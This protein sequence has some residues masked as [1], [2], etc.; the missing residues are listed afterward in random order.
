MKVPLQICGLTDDA[1]LLVV[2]INSTCTTAVT[3]FFPMRGRS[4]MKSVVAKVDCISEGARSLAEDCKLSLPGFGKWQSAQNPDTSN[5][6]LCCLCGRRRN[7]VQAI[8]L[9]L[10]YFILR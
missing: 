9:D 1:T 2:V 6:E 4:L 7:H 5:S 10:F 3:H 8:K